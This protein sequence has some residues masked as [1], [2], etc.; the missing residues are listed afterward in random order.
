MAKVVAKL[1]GT[2]KFYRIRRICNLRIPTHA[3]CIKS[4]ELTHHSL[5]FTASMS[6]HPMRH[7]RHHAN[8][9]PFVNL[10]AA[11]CRS[12]SPIPVSTTSLSSIVLR[13]C[14]YLLE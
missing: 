5:R 2:A 10:F 13:Q 8:F 11:S 12:G 3:S 1:G 6:V 9:C 7:L 4:L 14:C